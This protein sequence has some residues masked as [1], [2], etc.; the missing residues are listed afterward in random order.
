MKTRRDQIETS[1]VTERQVE[2]KR[3]M[4]TQIETIIV[5]ERLGTLKETRIHERK[6]IETR[7]AT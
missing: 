2:P 4:K 3:D 6:Q 5:T 7:K 1:K